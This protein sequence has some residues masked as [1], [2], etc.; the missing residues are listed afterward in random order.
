MPMDYR[1]FVK[2]EIEGKGY[3]IEAT[4]NGHY[5][6]VTPSGGKL[7]VFAVAHGSG[8]RKEVHDCYVSR[9]K[10]CIKQDQSSE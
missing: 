10:K 9:V 8:T 5:W 2:E 3:S 4:T 6:V 1:K 7:I